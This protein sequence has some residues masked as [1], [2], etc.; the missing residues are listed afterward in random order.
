M[1]T[2]FEIF[3]DVIGQWHWR[4]RAKNSRI[5]ACSVESY[6]RKNGAIRGIKAVKRACHHELRYV[7]LK[8]S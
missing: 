6:S 2:G 3:Q 8:K 1:Q 5:I 7:D 4:L